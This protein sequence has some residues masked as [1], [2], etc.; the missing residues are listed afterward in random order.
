MSKQATGGTKAIREEHSSTWFE[1]ATPEPDGTVRLTINTSVGANQ[2]G[3]LAK[4]TWYWIFCADAADVFYK[5]GESAS[6][7]DIDLTKN[8]PIPQGIVIPIYTGKYGF[9][10]IKASASTSGYIYVTQL[11]GDDGRTDIAP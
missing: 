10:S 6:P 4:D 1:P 9:I 2:K 5:L 7:T 8:A 11:R 3:T